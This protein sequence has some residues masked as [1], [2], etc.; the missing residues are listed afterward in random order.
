MPRQPKPIVDEQFNIGGLSDSKFSGIP[1]SVHRLV[2]IDLHSKPGVVLA[3]QALAKTSSSTVTGLIKNRVAC[4]DGNSYW[5]DGDSGKVYKCTTGGTVTLV[6]TTT[7]DEGGAQCLGAE[8]YYGYI[9][10]ATPKRLHRIPIDKL[11][12]W[13]TGAEEDWGL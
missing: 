3:R 5:F 13:T 6:H 8:E 11:S 10:W 9:Y 7:P 2:G 4:S 1:N 12:N